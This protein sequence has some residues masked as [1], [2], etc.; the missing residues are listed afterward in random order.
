LSGSAISV[1]NATTPSS[2]GL[3]SLIQAEIYR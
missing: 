3:K 2:P 1:W